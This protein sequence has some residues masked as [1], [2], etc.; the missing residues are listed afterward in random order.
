MC[1]HFLHSLV[2]ASPARFQPHKQG[3]AQLASC[4]PWLDIR[5]RK[6]KDR[7][8]K[9]DA[10]CGIGGANNDVP[11]AAVIP[12]DAD[13][14]ICAEAAS[15]LWRLVTGR[16]RAWPPIDGHDSNVTGLVLHLRA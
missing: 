2:L 1:E 9:S 4:R 3:R 15:R 6:R 5:P 14:T 8:R 16:Q 11:A 7:D 12:L 10:Y 13:F